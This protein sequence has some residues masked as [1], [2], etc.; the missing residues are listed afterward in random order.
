[1]ELIISHLILL[2]FYISYGRETPGG[3]TLFSINLVIH[4]D[5][6]QKAHLKQ[7][8]RGYE[9]W[10]LEEKGENDSIGICKFWI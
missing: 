10:S 7:K 6:W 2:I 4:L 1:M 5:E 8:Q 9:A 3:I